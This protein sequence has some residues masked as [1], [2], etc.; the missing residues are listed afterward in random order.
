MTTFLLARHAEH[1][2]QGG[3]LV[4]RL[5]GIK[6]SARGV[7]QAA[8]LGHGLAG[9]GVERIVASPRE[10]AQT[11][12]SAVATQ[13]GLPVHTE[14]G[15]EEI[16]YGSWTGRFPAEL[17]GDGAWR[18]WNSL[19]ATHR[20]P[21]GESMLEVQARM[22]AVADRVVQQVPRGVVLLVSHQDPL[23]ALLAYWLGMPLDFVLRLAFEPA[24]V[25]VVELV[26]GWPQCSAVNRTYGEVPEA[27]S[28]ATR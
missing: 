7:R 9:V 16:D 15:L 17:E 11:T 6:L 8:A 20:I 18:L 21:N 22:V 23:R 12:A 19:R 4:G 2:E 5:E 28:S 13:L 24:S 27:A 1:M 10:R 3:R 25:S 26:E 14:P